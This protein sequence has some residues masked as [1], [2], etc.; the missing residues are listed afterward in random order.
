MVVIAGGC[1]LYFWVERNNY[2]RN[3]RCFEIFMDRKIP[4]YPRWI[5]LYSFLY[6]LMFGFTLTAIE[7]LA[8]G[9]HLIFGGIVLLITGCGICYLFPTEVPASCAWRISTSSQESDG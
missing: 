6:Y 1:Q 7:N 3:T 5:W 9:L 8:S 2:H 4:F